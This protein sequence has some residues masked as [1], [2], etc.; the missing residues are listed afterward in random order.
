[1]AASIKRAAP[2][3]PE[4]T[5]KLTVCD[6]LLRITVLTVCFAIPRQDKHD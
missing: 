4:I 1:M 3:F 2:V 6:I 5:V